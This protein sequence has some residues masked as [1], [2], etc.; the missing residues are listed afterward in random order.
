MSD[1]VSRPYDEEGRKT[2]D[3]LFGNK[4]GEPV[5]NDNPACE[6]CGLRLPDVKARPDRHDGMILLCDLCNGESMED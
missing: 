1:I 4:K 2:W 6:S 5:M 3:R